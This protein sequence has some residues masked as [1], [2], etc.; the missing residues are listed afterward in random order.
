MTFDEPVSF[1]PHVD[2]QRLICKNLAAFDARNRRLV[3]G[4]AIH[5]YLHF[6]EPGLRALH[7]ISDWEPDLAPRVARR[8][9]RP[10]SIVPLD[11]GRQLAIRIDRQTS[12][13]D[14]HKR[15][16]NA[17]AALELAGL[18]FFVEL[19]VGAIVVSNDSGA[20]RMPF[21]LRLPLER[22]EPERLLRDA[23]RELMLQYFEAEA[24]SDA[25]AV[26]VR[27]VEFGDAVLT[28]FRHRRGDNSPRQYIRDPE[29]GMLLDTLERDFECAPHARELFC[30]WYPRWNRSLFIFNSPFDGLETL[31]GSGDTGSWS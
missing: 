5:H 10:N 27:A 1:A 26:R 18:R 31:R 3:D 13:S 4:R 23:A 12:V 9:T 25:S 7:G 29:L 28:E 2:Q 6:V 24:S 17:M 19:A 14:A 22:I 8:E 15:V 30:C 20:E 16:A 21:T 11:G